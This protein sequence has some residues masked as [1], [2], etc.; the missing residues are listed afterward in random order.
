MR[1]PGVGQ[2]NIRD[3]DM[4][5][6]L[7]QNQPGLVGDAMSSAVQ[8]FSTGSTVM[9][10]AQA[11]GVSFDESLLYAGAAALFTFLN[12]IPIPGPAPN[13]PPR[14]TPQIEPPKEEEDKQKEEQSEKELTQEEEFQE[15]EPT[16]TPNPNP[17]PNPTPTPTPGPRLRMQLQDRPG[18]VVNLGEA[19][20]FLFGQGLAGILRLP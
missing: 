7:Q 19:S 18:D 17:N 10:M 6:Q 2:Q 15:E 3:V 1:V 8:A 4:P 20:N 12:T 5:L 13:P 11:S 14:D 9:S 16:P